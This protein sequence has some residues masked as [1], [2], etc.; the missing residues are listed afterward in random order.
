MGREAQAWSTEQ[1]TQHANSS[2]QA[3]GLAWHL[4]PSVFQPTRACL[5]SLLPNHPPDS[6]VSMTSMLLATSLGWLPLI[7]IGKAVA[8]AAQAAGLVARPHG[9]LD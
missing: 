3:T 1:A 6:S 5:H 7:K 9:V 2:A 8:R 4:S